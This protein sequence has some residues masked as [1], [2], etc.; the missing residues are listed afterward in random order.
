MD[1]FVHELTVPADGIAEQCR[2]Y[3]RELLKW[4]LNLGHLAF[5]TENICQIY[6][7]MSA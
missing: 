6:P 3:S 4:G 1:A 2:E 5:Q 7:I